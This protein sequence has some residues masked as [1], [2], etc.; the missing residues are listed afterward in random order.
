MIAIYKY[1]ACMT[2]EITGSRCYWTEIFGFEKHN[3]LLTLLVFE[4]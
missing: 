1:G 3:E 4:I 2:L